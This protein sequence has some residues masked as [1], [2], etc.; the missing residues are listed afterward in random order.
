MSN[1]LGSTE[2]DKSV[3]GK[4]VA[5]DSKCAQPKDAP[6][7][8]NVQCLGQFVN[9][10]DNPHTSGLIFQVTTPAGYALERGPFKT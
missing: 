6:A 3:A 4:V 1:I 10:A 9:P 8:L 7:G 5:F 2:V